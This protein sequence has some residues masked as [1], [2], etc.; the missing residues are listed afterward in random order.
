MKD[1]ELVAALR[2][3]KATFKPTVCLDCQK[4]DDCIINGCNLIGMAADRI[5]EYDSALENIKNVYNVASNSEKILLMDVIAIFDSAY[6]N[7]SNLRNHIAQEQKRNPRNDPLD[8]IRYA[9]TF[10]HSQKRITDFELCAD[11]A[12]LAKTLRCIDDNGYFLS[13]VTQDASGVYTIFFRRPAR[14]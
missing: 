7:P 13:G 5:A 14:E 11:T 10:T 9:C 8:A 12:E 1:T 4:G 2:S 6:G 3:L